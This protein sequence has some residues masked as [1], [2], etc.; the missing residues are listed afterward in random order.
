M[1]IDDKLCNLICLYRSP[2]QNMRLRRLLKLL[3]WILNLYLPRIHIWPSLLVTSLLVKW[4]NWYKGDKTT[5]SGI[6]LKVM[7]SQYG[8]T[9]IINEPTHILDDESSCINLIFTSQPDMVLDSRVNSSLHPSSHHQIVFAKFNL[10]VIVNMQIL[11]R[12]K[13][14]LHLSTGSKHFLIA[15]S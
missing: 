14:H 5:A 12:S 7:T 8:L 4:H 13:M 6:K 11:L 15:L 1:R 3:S 9:Q 2:N 10:K